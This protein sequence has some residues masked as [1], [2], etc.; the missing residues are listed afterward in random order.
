VTAEFAELVGLIRPRR[1]CIFTWRE[2]RAK[3]DRPG[4]RTIEITPLHC[5]ACVRE[6]RSLALP[7]RL[8]R[9]GSTGQLEHDPVSQQVAPCRVMVVDDDAGTREV[10]SEALTS[11]GCEVVCAANGQEALSRLRSEAPSP[12]LILLDLMMPVM[13][14]HA[15]RAEQERDPALA[16]I[17]TIVVT[18]GGD[19]PIRSVPI[20]RKPL[21]MAVVNRIVEAPPGRR[22]ALIP[23]SQPM[24]HQLDRC[25]LLDLFEEAV[26]RKSAVAV[27]LRGEQ[28][29]IDEVRDVVTRDGE[30]WVVFKTH[31]PVPLRDVR[32][33]S[34]A[35]PT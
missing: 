2:R 6:L 16:E 11:L 1:C 22:L 35:E 23:A 21:D 19:P 34:R 31:D 28:R 8:V 13:D 18:A 25:D 26:V 17:P 30:D 3:S 32:S 24:P 29:F 14:G 27:E 33:C 9:R 10:L 12:R 7:V 20:I 4:E 15:F 5:D